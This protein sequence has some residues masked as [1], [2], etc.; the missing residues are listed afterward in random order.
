M[1]KW[2]YVCDGKGCSETETLPD[3]SRAPVGWLTRTTIDRI[4]SL[5]PGATGT[6]MPH[7]RS[8][9]ERICHFCPSCRR[10]VV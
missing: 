2:T 6:G 5:E 1:L 8:E 10:K 7:G 9:L 3:F 4:D